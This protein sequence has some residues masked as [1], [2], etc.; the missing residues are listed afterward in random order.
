MPILVYPLFQIA[1][2]LVFVSF[3][4]ASMLG[5]YS[6]LS[7]HETLHHSLDSYEFELPYE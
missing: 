2:Y 7:T 4:V 3:L 5:L 1:P 6:T